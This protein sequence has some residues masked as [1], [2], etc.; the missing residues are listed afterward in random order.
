M[1]TD[2]E[3]ITRLYQQ[4]KEQG[5]PEQLDQL[6]LKAARQ[7][8]EQKP[9]ETRASSPFSG[10][11]LVAMPVAAVLVI[12]VILAPF[13]K[14]FQSSAPVPDRLKAEADM[15]SLVAQKKL[16]R[17]RRSEQ[18]IEM[19]GPSMTMAKAFSDEKQTSAAPMQE[20]A[21]DEPEAWLK[22]IRV[23]LDEGQV[24]LARKELQ[25][26]KIVYPGRKIER[27]LLQQI[28]TAR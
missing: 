10:A 5:P 21:V 20:V 16:E 3:K 8:V 6:I 13:I 18:K 26:F 1:S 4:G 11:W 24:D 19:P 23:L 12:I 28:E 15:G 17:L 2:E 9:V 27:S 14:Q 7:A 25:R 22:K